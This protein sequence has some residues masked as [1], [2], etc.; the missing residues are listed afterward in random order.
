VRLPR[1]RT[2]A[3][4]NSPHDCISPK[5]LPF[6]PSPRNFARNFGEIFALAREIYAKFLAEIRVFFKLN[7]L[8]IKSLEQCTEQANGTFTQPGVVMRVPG[9]SALGC[10]AKIAQALLAADAQ[11]FSR[12]LFEIILSCSRGEGCISHHHHRAVT[13]SQN[14]TFSLAAKSAEPPCSVA[15]FE[16]NSE[17]HTGARPSVRLC[18]GLITTN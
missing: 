7:T 1:P 16:V 5:F 12:W 10:T 18:V 2:R 9:S 6:V 3:T 8:E 14:F 17:R 15:A 13:G 4:R 11:L